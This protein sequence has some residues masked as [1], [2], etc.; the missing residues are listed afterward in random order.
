MDDSGATPDTTEPTRIDETFEASVVPAASDDAVS[1]ARLRCTRGRWR[2]D[3][4][5]R[6]KRVR[7]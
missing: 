5:F 3:R 4:S 6:A 1:L 2:V 7:R